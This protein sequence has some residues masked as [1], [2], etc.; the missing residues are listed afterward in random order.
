MSRR[1]GEPG[2]V[3]SAP[4]PG[5]AVHAVPRT[6]RSQRSVASAALRHPQ[7]A[8]TGDQRA[9][10]QNDRT[11]VETHKQTNGPAMDLH[12]DD[13]DDDDDLRSNKL[14]RVD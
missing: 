14:D 8:T 13:D 3:G 7:N 9:N 4:S 5:C 12:G 6:T 11:L 1:A 10:P 2:D